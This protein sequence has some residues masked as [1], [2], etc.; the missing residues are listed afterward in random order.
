MKW[1]M[2]EISSLKIMNWMFKHGDFILKK[3]CS[4]K[5]IIT[6]LVCCAWSYFLLPPLIS[7]LSFKYPTSLCTSFSFYVDSY[8]SILSLFLSLYFPL[9]WTCS[10]FALEFSEA[11]LAD[12]EWAQGFT[13]RSREWA[14]EQK[15]L[16]TPQ[17]DK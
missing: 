10:H 17:G 4:S 16:R 6:A 14:T 12:I 8:S 11:R 5:T 2:R 15:L 13:T 3:S 7:S 1:N 9:V